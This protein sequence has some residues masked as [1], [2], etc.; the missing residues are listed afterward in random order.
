MSAMLT[1]GCCSDLMGSLYEFMLTEGC[2]SDVK[3]KP[4]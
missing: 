4:I 1:E 3:G 2:C